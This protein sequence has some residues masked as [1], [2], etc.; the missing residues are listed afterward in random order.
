MKN[1][2]GVIVDGETEWHARGV[3]PSD[4]DTLCGTDANDPTLGH[5]GTLQPRRGQ[6][7]TCWQCHTIWRGVRELNLRQSSFNHAG[8][9]P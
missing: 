9:T 7:I 1:I 2:I 3:G 5:Q 4:Y 6:K 8:D